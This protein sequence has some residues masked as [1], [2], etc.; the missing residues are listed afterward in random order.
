MRDREAAL[1]KFGKQGLD[2]AERSF[3]GGGIAHMA[4]ARAAGEPAH[5]LVLVE[6]AGDMPHRAVR[7]EMLA[8]E[9]CDTRGFLAAMLKRVKAERDEARRIVGSPDA[10]DAALLAQLVVVERIGRQHVPSPAPA[11]SAPCNAPA[12]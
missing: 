1:G 4:D 6:I 12:I 3:A 11:P 5:D 10:E 7:V 2:V 8:I 9:R